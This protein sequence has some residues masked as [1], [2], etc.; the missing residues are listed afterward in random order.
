LVVWLSALFIPLFAIV[1]ALTQPVET[2]AHDAAILHLNRAVLFAAARSEA[3][4]F[5]VWSQALNAGL[6]GPLFTFYPPLLYFLM[7][8]LHSAGLSMPLA[9]RVVLA[10]ALLAASTGVFALVRTIGGRS[11]NALAAASIFTYALPLLR[12]LFERG[13]PQ[14][15]AVSLFPWA[16]WGLARV[17]QRPVGWRIGLATL[18]WALVILAHNLS[19]LILLPGLALVSIP[20]AWGQQRRLW[21]LSLVVLA[22][23]M[24]LASFSI[25]P[26]L[27]ER[28]FV[29]LDNVSQ[30]GYVDIVQNPLRLS[31]LLQS[32]PAYDLG[33]D[34]NAIG[35]HL[36]LLPAFG[37]LLGAAGTWLAWRDGQRR[38]AS[39]LGI[40]VLFG[41]AGLWLQT[42]AADWFWA[43]NPFLGL[44][45]FRARLLGAVALAAAVAIGCVPS[46]GRWRWQSGVVGSLGVLAVLGAWPVLYPELQYTYATFSP[47]PTVGEVQRASLNQ[48]VPGLTAFNEF[49]P[50]WRYEPLDAAVLS[51]V[52]ASPVANLPPGAE[53][54]SFE[55][56]DRQQKINLRTPRDF[57]AQ[58]LLLYFPGWMAY[59]DG[60]PRPLRPMQ[61]TGYALL[62]VPSGEHAVVLSYEGTAAQRLGGWIT[63]LTAL[64]LVGLAMGWRSPV[65]SGQSGSSDTPARTGRRLRAQA[66]FPAGLLILLALKSWWLDPHTTLFRGDSACSSIN[67]ANAQVRA[68]FG[69]DLR[70]C[71]YFLPQTRF[72]PG[73]WLEVTLYWQATSIPDVPADSFVHLLGTTF[74]PETGTPLWGQQD[75]QLPGEHRVTRWR[76]GKLYRD[77][78]R[79]Q[80]PAHTPPGDYQLE[81]GWQQVETGQRL[82]PV[83]EAVGAQLSISH[84]DALLV[85]G[86]EVK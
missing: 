17:I 32:P 68:R 49:L 83:L 27:A 71:G 50:R 12:D 41:L 39:L 65:A 16:L 36:G 37:L 44:V 81:I 48:N 22:G 55:R 52:E 4:V 74:N 7:G 14:G 82:R 10:L 38:S 13:S 79:F 84:L 47:N 57:T 3:W 25:V 18:I 24:L 31:D 20:L 75:K 23:G 1:P 43:A 34:N 26:F 46:W 62:D 42:T 6:G 33:L 19:A 60:Q 67:Q 53:I 29:Q 11:V 70:L 2:R 15:L 45:Q 73:D 69:E 86:I 59:L 40:F 63:T 5:P 35:D 56:T 78:Y 72:R 66:W 9:F 58:W 64:V 77:A 28:Q 51:Q 61:A 21:L 80:I 85:S 30:V 54:V 8:G 76:A